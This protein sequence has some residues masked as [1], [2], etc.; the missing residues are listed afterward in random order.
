MTE[1]DGH[2]RAIRCE[3]LYQE[4]QSCNIPS[5]I[6]P[7]AGSAAGTARPRMAGMMAARMKNFIVRCFD[8]DDRV[9][10]SGVESCFLLE[11]YVVPM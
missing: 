6:A 3:Q 11:I 2:P 8:N 1:G 4:K 10:L 7:S 5:R 9:K